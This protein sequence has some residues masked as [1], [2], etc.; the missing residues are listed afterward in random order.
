MKKK[1]IKFSLLIGLLFLIIGAC[2]IIVNL[3]WFSVVEVCEKI[4]HSGEV[5]SIGQMEHFEDANW[6]SIEMEGNVKVPGIY[7][8]PEGKAILD[9]IYMA[10]GFIEENLIYLLNLDKNIEFINKNKINLLFPNFKR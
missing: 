6:I 10:D 1:V 5:L 9:L 2:N 7:E 3:N 8:V 4:N